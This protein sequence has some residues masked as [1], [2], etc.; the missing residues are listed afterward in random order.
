MSKFNLYNSEKY[1]LDILSRVII[2]RRRNQDTLYTLYFA[3]ASFA[4]R[5]KFR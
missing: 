3:A 1:N 5:A 2:S 4:H